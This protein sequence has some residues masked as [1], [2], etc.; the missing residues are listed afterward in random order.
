MVDKIA[1]GSK[2]VIRYVAETVA[3]TT[4]NTP[5]M[6]TARFTDE[7]LTTNYNSA[8]SD[9]ITESRGVKDSIPVSA[10]RS[11]DVN[12]EWSAET[13]NDWLESALQN[14][15]SDLVDETGSWTFTRPASILI[16]TI[17]STTG[18]SPGQFIKI[19]GSTTASQNGIFQ[20]GEV[21]GTTLQLLLKIGGDVGSV[22]LTA[23]GAAVNI[24]GK[25]L[26]NG[27]IPQSFTLE[28]EF[29]GLQDNAV[30]NRFFTYRGMEVDN[31]ELNVAVDEIVTGTF[32]WMGR[33]SSNTNTTGASSNVAASTTPVINAVNNV[34]ALLENGIA[35]ALAQSFTISTTNNLRSQRAIGSYDAVGIG[36]GKFEASGQLEVFFTGQDFEARIQSFTET[37][38][39]I[40]F[41]DAA[42]NNVIISLPR[43]KL[44]NS[45]VTVGGN[46]EDIIAQIDYTALENANGVV[47]RIDTF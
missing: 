15:W 29:K 7:S 42:G 3:G 39:V 16:V 2:S 5:A 12:V 6:I 40:Q 35:N 14:T 11:G 34:G 23:G 47:I 9:E 28:K 13:Y 10:E 22:A 20:V 25:S 43:V 36:T 41:N 30:D 38:I 44:N 19:S 26:V 46:N 8:N 37:A 18:I 33:G 31:F 21:T 45:T 32:S 4:P 1:D 24:K 27:I 17:T